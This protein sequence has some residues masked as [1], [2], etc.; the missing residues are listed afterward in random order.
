MLSDAVGQDARDSNIVKEG[1]V[2]DEADELVRGLD[3][4]IAGKVA[5]EEAKAAAQAAAAAEA[6]PA[7]VDGEAA[8]P[9]EAT[10]AAGAST[11]LIFLIWSNAFFDSCE[12][13]R[14]PTSVLVF[15]RV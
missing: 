2:A 1:I 8:A 15:K 4:A 6:A 9:A 5:A 12:G 3:A 7:A 14:F 11:I 10:P 13:E